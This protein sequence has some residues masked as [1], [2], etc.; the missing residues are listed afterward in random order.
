MTYPTSPDSSI[1]PW[2]SG[3]APGGSGLPVTTA[4]STSDNSSAIAMRSTLS[5]RLP[6]RFE[7]NSLSSAVAVHENATPIDISSPMYVICA[8]KVRISEGNA[9]E[10]L[11]FL[12]F[13]EREYLRASAQRYEKQKGQRLEYMRI[14]N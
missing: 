8:A 1:Q 11:V 14:T 13:S 9:K 7:P 2:A 5:V 6:S 3:E 10:N 12:C 4:K